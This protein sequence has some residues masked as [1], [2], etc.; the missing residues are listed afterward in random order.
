[1]SMKAYLWVFHELLLPLADGA[2]GNM[3][4]M[5]SDGCLRSFLETVRTQAIQTEPLRSH[6]SF[7][8]DVDISVFLIHDL[9]ILD[10]ESVQ[11]LDQLL[12]D[13]GI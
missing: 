10:V 2:R 7:G 1:M 8:V 13:M 5:N 3:L 11:A 9:I 12:L 4:L 6:T